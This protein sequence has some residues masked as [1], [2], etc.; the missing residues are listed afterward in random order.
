MPD[1]S[2]FLPGPCTGPTPLN[3]GVP[4]PVFLNFAISQITNSA[5]AGWSLS[6]SSSQRWPVP[7]AR[8]L[9]SHRHHRRY[10]AFSCCPVR[11]PTRRERKP[12]GLARPMPS[13]SAMTPFDTPVRPTSSARLAALKS[14]ASTPAGPWCRHCPSPPTPRW[15][16]K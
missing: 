3:M 15:C 14:S 2:R 6:V 5:I 4:A 1:F 11:C 7:L 12:P 8:L 9:L 10:A 16:R 13:R